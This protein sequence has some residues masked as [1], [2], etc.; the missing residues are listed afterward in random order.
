MA[1]SLVR[2]AVIRHSRLGGTSLHRYFHDAIVPSMVFLEQ[3]KIVLSHGGVKGERDFPAPPLFLNVL[4]D[5][6]RLVY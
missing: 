3:I 1:V 6:F 4:L 2:S 5:E